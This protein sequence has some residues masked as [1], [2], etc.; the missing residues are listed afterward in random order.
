[1]VD[2][3]FVAGQLL[4]FDGSCTTPASMSRSMSAIPQSRNTSKVLAPMAG[5]EVGSGATVLLNRGAGAGWVTP[6]TW[7][8][9]S[10]ATT[11]SQPPDPTPEA[12]SVGGRAV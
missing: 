10:R 2:V 8:K 1:V 3:A 7:M 12:V 4:A 11:T 6:P 9:V 5:G